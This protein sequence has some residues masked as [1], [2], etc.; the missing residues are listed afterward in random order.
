MHE[1]RKTEST[2]GKVG[3]EKGGFTRGRTLLPLSPPSPLCLSLSLTP[4]SALLPLI[5]NQHS[6]SYLP[7]P[8]LSHRHR[9]PH[10]GRERGGDTC[11]PVPTHTDSQP[12]REG[13]RNTSPCTSFHPVS[14]CPSS[15]KS[16]ARHA[17]SP[18]RTEPADRHHA[19]TRPNVSRH[20]ALTHGAHFYR[21]YSLIG[22]TALVI[23]V[24]LFPPSN[25]APSRL[26]TRPR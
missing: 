24:P 22:V 23:R 4:P 17:P 19:D 11:T 20:L 1:G 6:L 14:S 2:L 12:E 7:P 10:G 25:M 9:L 18:S 5:D 3:R 21:S 26:R 13:G 16:C 8:L 15:R